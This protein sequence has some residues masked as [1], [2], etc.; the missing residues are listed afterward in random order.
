M[1]GKKARSKVDVHILF[2][3]DQ[4]PKHAALPAFGGD[5]EICGIANFYSKECNERM[6]YS[7]IVRG[8]HG[9][10]VLKL[11]ANLTFR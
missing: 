6:R 11:G 9:N 10:T 5:D 3:K 7:V 8:M 1:M 4:S 2:E